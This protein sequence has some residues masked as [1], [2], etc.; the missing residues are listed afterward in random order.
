MAEGECIAGFQGQREGDSELPCA[1][2]G[3]GFY[4]VKN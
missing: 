3:F 4:S 2:E 1:G